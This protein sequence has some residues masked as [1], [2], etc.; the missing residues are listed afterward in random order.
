MAALW[1][2]QVFCVEAALFS[3]KKKKNQHAGMF[4]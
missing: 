3:K 4:P 1:V 2:K